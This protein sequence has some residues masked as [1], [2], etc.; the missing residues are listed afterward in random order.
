MAAGF[1]VDFAIPGADKEQLEKYAI[2]DW[3]AAMEQRKATPTVCPGSAKRQCDLVRVDAV[4]E[5]AMVKVIVRCG[6]KDVYTD[7]LSQLKFSKGWKIVAKIYQ[8]SP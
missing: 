8:A 2:K 1:H 4:G 3:I 5:A 6:G 7:F